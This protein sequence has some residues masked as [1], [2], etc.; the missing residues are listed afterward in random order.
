VVVHAC[1]TSFKRMMQDLQCKVQASASTYSKT[2]SSETKE[3]EYC[4]TIDLILFSEWSFI[5]YEIVNTVCKIMIGLRVP[6]RWL[7]G[8]KFLSQYP[9]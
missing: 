3:R 7:R 1:D 6:E 4:F 9:H 2:L 8:L 5:S